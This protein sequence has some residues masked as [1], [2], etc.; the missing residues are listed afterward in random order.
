MYQGNFFLVN[1]SKMLEAEMKRKREDLYST[2]H[3]HSTSN[4]TLPRKKIG[5][6]LIYLGNYLQKDVIAHS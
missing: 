3:L 6:F 1:S 5:K 4:W 2:F